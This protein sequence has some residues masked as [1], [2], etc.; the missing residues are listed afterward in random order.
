[1]WLGAEVAVWYKARMRLMLVAFALLLPLLAAAQESVIW[2][3]PSIEQAKPED[4]KYLLPSKVAPGLL[5]YGCISW[6]PP[7][8]AVSGSRSSEP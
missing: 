4:L 8:Q 2:V 1:V 5:T 6:E 3:D 7:Q